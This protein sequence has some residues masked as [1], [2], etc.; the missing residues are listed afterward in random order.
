MSKLQIL[1]IVLMT[2]LLIVSFWPM[3][4]E[5]FSKPKTF[6]RIVGPESSPDRLWLVTG[7]DLS[8]DGDHV[9]IKAQRIKV[10]KGE[11]HG[12]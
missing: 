6:V 7:I 11:S 3:I 10:S 5:K 8:N 2:G 1:T 12:D 4:E 9:V